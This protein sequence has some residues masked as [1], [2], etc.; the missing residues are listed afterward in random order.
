MVTNSY[1]INDYS[2]NA[3]TWAGMKA[4]AAA[5][6]H[7]TA[8]Y[9]QTTAQSEYAPKISTLIGEKCG[10]IITVEFP[11]G[12]ATEAAARAHPTQDF[13]IVDCSYASGCLTGIKESNIDQ[14]V[15]NTAQDAFL[16]GYLAAGMTKTGKVATFGGEE[17]GTITISMDGFWD[18]VQYY[19]QRHHTNV[20]VLGWNERTQKGSFTG[21]FSNPAAGRPITRKF[22]SERADIIFPV[23][24]NVG[25]G[26]ANVVQHADQASGSDTVNMLW[27][28]NDGCVS[29]PQYCPYFI[30]SVEKGITT[31][32][33]NAVLSAAKGSFAGGTHVGTL[34]N[35]GALLAPFHHFSS[36]VPASLRRELKQVQAGIENGTIQVPA[37]SPA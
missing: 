35:G 29:W 30:T 8:K 28:E 26:A 2:F 7:I 24:G 16:A 34:A 10:L 1:G 19:N 27:M 23:G 3:L 37:Q 11:E 5:D 15:F 21:D 20:Q 9:L 22:I 32:V 33:R 6:P 31:A 18:G 12:A 14:L 17:Y 13:A 25:I 36:K 4:A